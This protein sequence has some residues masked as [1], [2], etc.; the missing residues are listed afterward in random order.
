[1]CDDVNQVFHNAIVAEVKMPYK[2]FTMKGDLKKKGTI[3][4]EVFGWCKN[5]INNAFEIYDHIES[6]HVQ[7]RKI[8]LE[9]SKES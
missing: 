9:H 7:L 2:A 1:M 5:K 4:E 6:N 3:V 8:V